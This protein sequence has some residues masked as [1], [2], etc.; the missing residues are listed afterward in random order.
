MATRATAAI[1]VSAP[2]AWDSSTGS[3][4]TELDVAAAARVITA[5]VAIPSFWQRQVKNTRKDQAAVVETMR[6]PATVGAASPAALN[7]WKAGNKISEK[8]A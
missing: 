5:E 4:K 2:K 8:R 6:T 3:Q 1:T 7:A